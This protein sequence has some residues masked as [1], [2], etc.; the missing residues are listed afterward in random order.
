MGNQQMPL[1]I[2]DF[3]ELRQQDYY[4]VDKSLLIKEII[5][6]GFKVFLALRPRRFGKTLHLSM[7]KYFFDINEKDKH[8]FDHLKITRAGEKYL[9]KQ[10]K[11]PIIFITFKN[12]KA[13]NWQEALKK[14]E[15]VISELYQEHAYLLDSPA[16]SDDE[17]QTFTQIIHKKAELSD[18]E[19]SVKDLSYYLKKH[20]NETVYILIDEYDTPVHEA[21]HH[22]YT[23]DIL[24]FMCGLLGSA[25]KGNPNLQQAIVTGIL[26]IAKESLFSGV[27]NII[28]FSVLDDGLSNYFGWTKQ[29]VEKALDSFQLS[30]SHASVQVWYDGYTVGNSLHLYN[31]WSILSFIANHGKA[32]EPYWVNTGNP[33]LIENILAKSDDHTKK[34]IEQLLN[35]ELLHYPIDINLTLANFGQGD[36][37]WALLLF[38]G[39]LTTLPTKSLIKETRPL[40]IPNEEVK[41]AFTKMIRN[42][43][44][45]STKPLFLS[46]ILHE[47]TEGNINNF[48]DMLTNYLEE[49]LSY[50]DVKGKEPE[51]FY[52][53]LVLGM[54]V[55]LKNTH[56][57]TSNRESG[58]GRYDVMVV[59]YDNNKP[60]IIIEFKKV[61]KANNE[62]L[63]VAAQKGLDQIEE[64]QYALSLKT[65]KIQRAIAISIAFLGKKIYIL[66]KSILL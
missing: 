34:S 4:F 6:K 27:N 10:N 47:L 8:L 50:F 29:E 33:A 16:I 56:T 39:Y 13:K 17:K 45:Q 32:L 61:N 9:Q 66:E 36:T 58:Y 65:K 3:K 22:Q 57:I 60:G 28:T 37:L 62:T 52:H 14:I 55:E 46:S 25:L 19:F 5:D 2:D 41:I 30:Q 12:V 49:V 64:K 38:S 51:R 24:P 63:A 35:G 20:F 42:W 31:P 40:K 54:I 43:F 1:G 23:K 44:S 26:R 21:F 18:L 7:L 59:P 15:K 11:Y 53:A 48:K